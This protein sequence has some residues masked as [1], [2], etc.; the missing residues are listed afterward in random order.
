MMKALRNWALVPA[1]MMGAVLLSTPALAIGGKPAV[2]KDTIVFAIGRDIAMLDAQV[3]NT[4]NSD[5]YAWQ[6]FDNLY[7]F[8]KQGRL[9]PQAARS[10]TISDDGLVYR[11]KLRNDVKFHNGAT[12][13]AEDVKFSF[14][15]IVDPVTK[16]TRRPY[17][18]GI[19]EKVD[20]IDA[21]TVDVRLSKRDVVFMNKVASFV[22]LVPKAYIE[23]L[24]SIEAFAKAPVG[25]GPYK[26]VEHKIGQSLELARFDDYYGAKPGVKRLIFKFI[27]DASSRLNALMTGE[28]DMADS[29]AA[30]DAKRVESTTGLDAIPVPMGS[31]LHI[32]LYANEPNTP[33][34]D[35]RVR[36]ALNYAID[37]DAIIKSVLHGIGKPMSTFISS[38]YPVGV[39]PD[40]K[41]YGYDP[42]K[43]KKL[44]AEAG[45]PRGFETE[46]LSPT[47]Y[48]KDVTEAVAAYWS[49]VGVRAKIKMLDYP[50]WNRLN[51]THKSGPM[52]VMQYSNAMYDPITPIAGTASKAGTW[53]DYF[54]PEVE[55]LIEKSN[56][57][58][59]T[60]ERDKLFRQIARIMRD[61]GHAVL[62]SELFSVF[63]K[64]SAISWEP[65]A[66]YAFYDLR[67]VT[68]K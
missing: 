43:A 35:P 17:F 33:L 57:V 60:A 19:V 16:S 49:T 62:I 18:A 68:W 10:V 32:R 23:S 13:T 61:D 45:F 20:V 34:H 9:T 3:D 42:A 51:N 39:D 29:I 48:P 11:F 14:D 46:L 54:N 21:E 50:A 56:S 38:Y 64:D 2:D 53:S 24:P 4:G 52:T 66:G 41:P 8:D 15:R 67:T 31:P 6:L 25:A 63:A 65:Q 7:T 30:S 28:V 55:A 26:L 5:R 40:L 47:S 22:A 58:A 37:V 59:D 1:A 27:P 36:L 44:L 12:M